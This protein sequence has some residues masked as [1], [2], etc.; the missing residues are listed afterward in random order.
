MEGV[1]NF[2]QVR[3]MWEPVCLSPYNDRLQTGQSGLF[4]VCIMPDRLRDPLSNFY[5]GYRV[6]LVGVKRPRRDVDHSRQSSA[7][8]SEWSYTSTPH[9]RLLGVDIDN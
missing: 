6:Y 8:V 4:V 1:Q 3:Y 7:E 9:T 2:S 5:N